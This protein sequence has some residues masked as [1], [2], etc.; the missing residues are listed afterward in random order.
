[1]RKVGSM[2]KLSII[3]PSKN[4]EQFIGK[5]LDSLTS[6]TMR[7]I[8]IICVDAFS[9][10]STR[11]IIQDYMERDSRV[12]LLDDNARSSGYADNLGFK[13]AKGEYVAIVE[14]DD[15]VKEDMMEVLYNKAVENDLDYIKADFS[16]FIE[17]NGDTLTIDSIQS[18]K[19]LG[20]FNKVISPSDYPELLEL[21]GYMWKGIYKK[22]FIEKNKIKLNE[23]K[24]AAYQDNGFLHQ[25]IC[26][27]Q[28]AMYIDESF[29]QYRR[30]NENS[31]DYNPNGLKMMLNEYKFIEEFMKCNSKKVNKFYNYFYLKMF[32]QFRGQFEKAVRFGNYDSNLK[33]IIQQ[34]KEL[35]KKGIIEGYIR[36]DEFGK[37]LEEL[38]M[39]FDDDEFYFNYMKKKYKARDKCYSDF[40]KKIKTNEKVILVCCGDKGRNLYCLLRKNGCENI[41]AVCD[42]QKEKWETVFFDKRIKSVEYACEVYKDALFVIAND[43]YH[44]ELK[45]QLLKLGIKNE[46]IEIFNLQIFPHLSTSQIIQ[47]KE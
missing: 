35:L 44:N 13:T 15:Y 2:C 26:Q 17:V 9:T 5:C 47:C 33:D 39:F 20:I 41:I 6:Q 12:C 31:S 29:Y 46:S 38:Y 10:D 30:D 27:A 32:H 1:M 22:E 11:K 36:Q 16:M 42:N 7:D 43:I 45:R 19:K 18:L 37:E 4:M 25:T 3:V 28:R 40:I 23:T 8:E 14:S 24:G 21:D 34:Y